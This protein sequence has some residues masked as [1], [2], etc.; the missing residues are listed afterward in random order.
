MC[1]DLVTKHQERL[2]T[3]GGLFSGLRVAVVLTNIQQARVYTRIITAGGGT[4]LPLTNLRQ[5]CQQWRDISLETLDFVV[6]EGTKQEHWA[7]W[8]EILKKSENLKLR[9]IQ[10]TYFF[11]CI[12]QCDRVNPGNFLI[13]ETE[14]RK[15]CSKRQLGD[16]ELT[17]D[18]K[19][20]RADPELV[21][22]DS[23]EEVDSDEDIQIL[24]QK[25]INRKSEISSRVYIEKS[26]KLNTSSEI[27]EL[28]DSSDEENTEAHTQRDEREVHNQLRCDY[29]KVGSGST[30]P[31]LF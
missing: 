21:T 24:E 3:S 9:H 26:S 8:K 20:L 12:S 25:I 22:I 17:H 7:E 27:I 19:R 13:D 11:N 14:K 6:L 29:D 2:E 1:D 4:V 23:D 10:Y 31:V 18:V 5:L 30:C 28:G 15:D 16:G